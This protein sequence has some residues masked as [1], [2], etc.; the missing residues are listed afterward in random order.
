[1]GVV[2]VVNAFTKPLTKLM[3]SVKGAIGKVYEPRYKRRMADAKAYEIDKIGEALRN[4]SDVLITYNNGNVVQTL[5]EFEEFVQRTKQRFGYQELLKQKNIEAVVDNAY[6]ELEKVESVSEEPVNQ[7]WM[8]RF[9]NCVEDIGD[10]EMQKIWGK[11]LAGEIKK[12]GSFSKRTLDVVKNLSPEEANAFDSIVP[13]VLS[14]ESSAFLP[15]AKALLDKYK[16]SYGTILLLAES[17]LM[18][19]NGFISEGLTANETR[20]PIMHYKGSAL[21]ITRKGQR[22]VELSFGV[23]P[24]TQAGGELYKIIQKESKQEYLFDFV[25]TLLKEWKG[26]GIR[27]T[28]HNASLN[29]DGSICCQEEVLKEWETTTTSPIVLGNIVR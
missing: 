24:L 5:P 27:I 11:V 6:E 7:D 10:E 8:S 13:F 17:G 23:Y 2:D 12:P 4:N 28:M 3:D 1:M 26:K 18:V 20:H 15:S 9:F 22:N 14:D 16:V 19:S 29:N 25:E 21:A